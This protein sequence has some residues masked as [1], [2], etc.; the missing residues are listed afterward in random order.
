MIA[1]LA[2]SADLDNFKRLFLAHGVLGYGSQ[3]AAALNDDELLRIVPMIFGLMP[4][5]ALQRERYDVPIKPMIR[6]HLANLSISNDDVLV[7]IIKN[8]SDQYYLSSD[9]APTRPKKYSISDL[10]ALRNR[11]YEAI[12]SRQNGRCACC[13]VV[14]DGEERETLDHIIPYR[15]IGDID[16]GSNWQILCERCNSGK[17]SIVSTML[18][19]EAYNWIY[20]SST[21][22]SKNPRKIS[23]TTRFVVLRRDRKCFHSGC[24]GTATNSRLYVEQGLTTG[25]RVADCLRTVCHTHVS[26]MA[27][28]F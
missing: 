10:R 7:D 18:C 23:P 8:V 20:G 16:D 5:P 22:Y 17:S 28:A 9:L 26:D 14:F 11:S 24:T 25:L 6:D 13:G 4:E 15:L 1:R 3:E 21:V 12:R 27:L 2:H 19:Y